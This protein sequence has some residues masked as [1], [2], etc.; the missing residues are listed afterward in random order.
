MAADSGITASRLPSTSRASG[1]VAS[2]AVG[3]NRSPASEVSVMP[4]MEHDQ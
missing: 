4:M 1:S 2:A 3:A